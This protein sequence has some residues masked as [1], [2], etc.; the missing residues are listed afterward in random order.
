MGRKDPKTKECAAPDTRPAAH[1]LS[2][3]HL[4]F[5]QSNIARARSLLRLLRRELHTLPFA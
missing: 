3:N 4:P 1:P 2:R 5:D